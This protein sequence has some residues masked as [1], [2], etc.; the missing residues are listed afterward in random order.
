[1]MIPTSHISSLATLLFNC[2][3]TRL[4]GII[5]LI[6][7]NISCRVISWISLGCILRAIYH[8]LAIL[9]LSSF[10]TV[11]TKI[12]ILLLNIIVI[13]F[14]FLTRWRIT[15]L[16]D[17]RGCIIN[18]SIFIPLLDFL[19][20]RLTC[21]IFILLKPISR[22]LLPCLFKFFLMIICELLLNHLLNHDLYLRV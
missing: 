11:I 17:R 10:L 4:L 14:L 18:I 20:K 13:Q 9:S 19:T 16:I 12:R 2:G 6:L 22:L 8:R 1:M 7:L 21:R 5:S 3:L 15:L